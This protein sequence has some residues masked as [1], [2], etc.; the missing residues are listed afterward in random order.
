MHATKCTILSVFLYT[1]DTLTHK[2]VQY[3][4]VIAFALAGHP[5]PLYNGFQVE[6]II[7]CPISALHQQSKSKS[8]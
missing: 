1:K 7:E 3:I 5:L 6:S 4:N 8:T 2:K